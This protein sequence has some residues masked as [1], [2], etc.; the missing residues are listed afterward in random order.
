[1]ETPTLALETSRGCWWGQKHQCTFCG[2][3][4]GGMRYRS[5]SPGRALAEI[6]FLVDRYPSRRFYATD[7]I[8]PLEYYE[9]VLAELA[10]RTRPP[11]LYYE[12]KANLTKAQVRLLARAGFWGVYLGI[13][14]LSTSI[15]RL[16][17]KG[18]SQLLNIRTLKWCV[19]AGL[20]ADWALLCGFPGED[21]GEYER[22]AE[23]APSL[24]HLPPPFGP[25]HIRVDRFSPYFV[26]PERH[27]L[28]N[29]RASIAYRHIYPFPPAELDRLAYYF[30]YDYADE[31]TP[32][33]HTA[34]LRA[35]IAEW[36][37]QGQHGMA[38]LEMDDAGDRVEIRDTRP[39]ATQAVTVLRG[40]ARLAYR[41]LDAGATADAVRAELQRVL[42]AEAPS[43]QKIAGWL[44]Q[45][46]RDRLVIQEGSRYLSL[47][48]NPAERVQLPVARFLAQLAGRVS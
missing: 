30:D 16:M 47:A 23:L 32:E 38:R 42:G 29:L 6:D 48:T 19:E 18:T 22:L 43:S 34:P 24:M 10:S 7:N 25:Y 3:N 21:P 46:L 13:E 26:A 2:L 15:L 4:G 40:P 27:G 1:V 5:K 9:T 41:A 36:Q 39:A 11:H 31:R 20:V 35:A 45:W 28:A 33:E 12:T 17:D 37:A 8:L 14:S 44:D